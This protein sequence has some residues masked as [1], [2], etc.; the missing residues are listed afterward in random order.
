MK[1]VA[2]A[3]FKELEINGKKVSRN[4]DEMFEANQNFYKASINAIKERYP[5]GRIPP[6]MQK[7]IERYEARLKFSRWSVAGTY[8]ASGTITHEYGHI[9]ADQYWGMINGG[10]AT[11]GY[12]ND[13]GNTKKNMQYKLDT[14]FRQAKSNGDI[15]NLSKYG[16][17]DRD[18]FFAEAFCAREHGE[19]LPDYIENIVKEICN[20][21]A[22]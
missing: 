10:W 18:E 7:Q 8:G 5:S 1:A 11:S 22:L 3:N 20:G 15:Y 12:L 19:K 2:R 17:T 6:D 13:P 4:V 9:I 21:S 16:A 14:V